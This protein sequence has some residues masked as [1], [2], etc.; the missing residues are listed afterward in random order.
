MCWP[1]SIPAADGRH[2]DAG[3][4]LPA[5]LLVLVPVHAGADGL[6]RTLYEQ[7]LDDLTAR[8]EVADLE[9]PSTRV[10]CAG[11]HGAAGAGGREG[12]VAVPAIQW[13]RLAR[14][15]AS[16]PA[17]DERSLVTAL[18]D[19]IDPAGRKLHPAMP[20][21]AVPDSLAPDIVAALRQLELSTAKGVTADTIRIAAPASGNGDARATIVRLVLERY[22]EGLNAKGGIYGRA[23][24][25][26]DDPTTAFASVA[27]PGASAAVLDL[28]PLVEAPSAFRLL[29]D[30]AS[31]ERAVLAAAR[32]DDP[33]AD[34]L[35]ILAP[36]DRPSAS[37]IVFGGPLSA[38]QRFLTD[39][40]DDEPL[41][42]YLLDQR[43]ENGFLE[44]LP[45]RAVGIHWTHPL[46]PVEAIPMAELAG[47][48]LAA[49]AEP[50]A[51][52]AWLGASLLEQALRATGRRLDVERFT[53]AARGL[54]PTDIP[55]FGRVDP[56]RGLSRVGLARFDLAKRTVERRWLPVP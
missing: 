10:P 9:L 36:G 11:C 54:P 50:I 49:G 26:V 35:D 2:R 24:A 38:L 55:P 15:L 1:R 20:R 53:A 30:P 28:W 41:D 25:L 6:G 16:R 18:R 33:V 17:Y 40:P 4:F 34:R 19:G 46:L 45:R 12:G 37:A 44:S 42:V 27:R 8:L 48:D 14:P 47:L 7:G 23:I 56:Q 43:L 3:R 39:W 21:Y 31:V 32:A 5:L 51:R 22:V 13:Q 52:A 29:P